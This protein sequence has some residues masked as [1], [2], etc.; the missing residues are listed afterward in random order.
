MEVKMS[1]KIIFTD[2][3]R[4]Q[5]RRLAEIQCTQNEIAHVMGISKSTLK[6]HLLA[7]IDQGK[8]YGKVKL[9]RAQYNKAV[10]EGNPTML[11]WLGKQLLG[12]ADQPMSSENNLVLPW[13]GFEIEE[14]EDKKE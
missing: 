11:I 3:Q 1:Q 8:S 10:E 6:N 9:R 4:E 12:Q 7:E 5:V 2:E 14:T 13:E